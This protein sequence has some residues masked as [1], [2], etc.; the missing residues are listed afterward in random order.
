MHVFRWILRVRTVPQNSGK[1]YFCDLGD[2]FKM[3]GPKNIRKWMCL[4]GIWELE[5]F[6]K[7]EEKINF[8]DLGDIFKI[9]GPQNIKLIDV[10]MCWYR[11]YPYLSH[12]KH[13]E[14]PYTLNNKSIMYK[15]ILTMIS[16][17]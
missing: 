4:A 14:S 15:W 8:C 10:C 1:K 5:L 13:W 11:I 17:I 6:L 16:I 7:I 2:I 9:S 3:Y 12:L